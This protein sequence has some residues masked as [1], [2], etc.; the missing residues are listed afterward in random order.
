MGRRSAAGGQDLEALRVRNQML[1]QKAN[2]AAF[3]LS[4][5]AQG[6][7]MMGGGIA[8]K[9]APMMTAV[10]GAIM[11]MSMVQGPIS[12]AV[13]GIGA[14]A[15]AAVMVRRSFDKAQDETLAFAEQMGASSKNIRMF[16]EA[17][18][19]VSAGEVMERRR[20]ERTGIYQIQPGKKTFGQAF[21]EG[22]QGKQM[23]KDVGKNIKQSGQAG[24]QSALVS[25]MATAVSSGAMSAEQARSV[26]ANIAQELGDYS[27]GM[28]V[29]A[30][31]ISIL[32]PN[33]EN[34]MTDPLTV[35][36]KLIE[37]TRQRM[38]QAAKATNKSKGITLGDVG[39]VGGYALAGA[40]SGAAMGAGIGATIGGAVSFGT[41]ALP[42]AAVGAIAGTIIGGIAGATYGRK[43]RAKRMGETSGAQVALQKIALEQQQELLDSMDLEYQ[44]KIELLK[45][46]GK[47]VEAKKL[48]AEYDKNRQTLVEENQKTTEQVTTSFATSK[49]QSQLMTGADK[50]ITAKY[51]D[52]ALEDVATLSKSTIDDM[53]LKDE[54]KYTLKMQLA[55][56]QLDPMQVLDIVDIFKTKEDQEKFFNITTKFGGAV[57]NEALNVASM[58]A[59]KDGTNVELQKQIMLEVGAAPTSKEAQEKIDFWNQ[60]SKLGG[61]LD[62]SIVGNVI[63]K[64]VDKQARLM[65][66]FK[67]IDAKKGKIEQKIAVKMLG[68]SPEAIKTL[69]EN[70][71]YYNALPPEQQKVY[72]TS[73]ITTT[74][75]IDVNNA[76][77]QAYLK[78][79]GANPRQMEQK[80]FIESKKREFTNFKSQQITK[81]A[82]DPTRAL[83]GGKGAGGK[84][85]R[86]TTFDDL[87]MR[88]KM[89]QSGSI[90]AL[91]G[92]K[93]LKRVMSGKDKISLT[94]FKGIDQQL[95]GNGKVSQEFLDFIDSL[96]PEGIQ[97]DLKKFVTT[98][99]DGLMTLN[100]AGK[101]IMRGMVAAKLGEYQVNIRNNVLALK[102]QTQATSTLVK[103]GFTFAEAQE[104]AKDQTLA[105]AIANNELSPKQ[106]QKL[107]EETQELTHAQKQYERV[108]KIGLMDAMDGQKARFEMV[109]KFVA[110]QEQLIENQY[111]SEKAILSSRQEANE[112]ALEKISQEEEKINEKYDKQIE[113]L[114]KIAVKQEEINQIQQRRFGLAQALAGGDM[115]GAAGA[116][117]EIRQAEAAAQIERKRKA[118][119]DSR[120]KQLAGIEFGGKT[121]EK[122][123]ADNKAIINSLSDIEERIRLAKNALDDELKKTIGMTRVEIESAVTGIAKALDAGIDPNNKDFLGQILQ[124]VVGDANATVTALK[125]VGVQVKELLAQQSTKKVE[126]TGSGYSDEEIKKQREAEAAAKAAAEAAAKAAA[127]GTSTS[128]PP[129]T[130]HLNL[131]TT[132][133]PK[134]ADDWATQ[135]GRYLGGVGPMPVWGAK[136]TT[137]KTNPK[138]AA[139]NPLNYLRTPYN[140]GGMVPKYM[141]MGGVVPKYFAAGGYGK[142]TDTIPAMLTPGEFVIQKRAVDMLGTGV[143]NS[144]NNGEVLGNSVYNY[145]LSVN[146]SNSNAN[147]NDIARTVINQIKQIDAQRIRG[148]R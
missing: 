121:R 22:E 102:Q 103:A 110:L 138:P 43:D 21:A 1:M 96:G 104:L 18:G 84:K 85:E 117:Q 122:I 81:I 134:A 45:A 119:E 49:A 136:Q 25:Q 38:D 113:A 69:N 77:F 146:V 114:D 54:Q 28:S 78:E 124:G 61:V 82:G 17:A 67:Q 14:I 31:L 34:L 143:M 99:K 144:I 111:A 105:L 125:A 26:V 10:S 47:I 11:A 46:E 92:L 97:K 106:L 94:K 27:F 40:G 107:K 86:D 145:S 71:D 7:S 73:L 56:G 127:G 68:S 55:S 79:T 89:V 63:S 51:K 70:L 74:E 8:D 6:A 15:I 137:P 132:V 53:E 44:R 120:K 140:S 76:E 4:A 83:G 75:T 88:L 98:G 50:A 20:K 80:G 72:L 52:T 66:I 24:A 16:A 32:G 23:T 115:A 90:N 39:N 33:G 123:E 64:D 41:L 147:P 101:A 60:I 30:K 62:V 133:A 129:F 108:E 91:G 57:S 36:T 87:L 19:K 130:D 148:N 128:T 48:Q 65:D 37:D 112:Y 13:V 139:Y 35:R 59:G 58:F 131:P 12:A 5:V 9:V 29:N 95:L 93:E 118:I 141:A 2:M 116:I 126:L 100:E 142:G 42:A 135:M 109:Q 3:G